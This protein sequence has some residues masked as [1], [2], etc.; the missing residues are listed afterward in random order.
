MLKQ[1]PK[2]K[3][4]CINIPNSMQ[5]ILKYAASYL[6]GNKRRVLMAK[7][8]KSLGDGGQRLAESV[9]GWNRK[10][11]RKGMHELNS[12]LECIDN[13]SGRGRRTAEYY[14][15]ELSKNI[16]EIVKPNSQ[17]DPTFRTN[18]IYTPLTA[19]EVRFRLIDL[20]GYSKKKLP[21]IRTIRNKMN[22]LNFHPD[23]VAKCRPLK[24]IKE[25]DAIFNQVF[26]INKEADNCDK[27]L[28]LSID[29]KAKVNIGLFSRGGKNRQG[30]KAL[31]HDFA[32]EKIITP[33]GIFLPFFD[34]SF[35]YFTESKVTADFLVDCLEKLWP[36][37][38]WRFNP[39]MLVINL[40]NGP[41]NNSHR[42]QFIKRITDFAFAN[43][44][45]IK[46][47]YYPPYHSKY[48]PIER[49]WGILENHW[50]G[51]VINSVEKAL[52]LARSM[53]YNGIHPNVE[54]IEGINSSGIKLDK[55]EMAYYEQK[56]VRLPGLEKWF[57]DIPV[58]C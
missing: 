26:K 4:I 23:K 11:I 46:L 48:N 30:A 33:V 50:N 34:E 16:T 24:K 21:C 10:T 55:K 6:K 7:T 39:D 8:V 3:S 38:K 47:A 45:S 28:R 44:V 40:D 35:M 20:K 31:D 9:L 32:P 56:I 49:V 17:V 36:K 51:E 54:L 29:A 2:E 43:T 52:G 25:T 18:K 22:S 15:S 42:T 37:L 12:G 53:T 19:K 27:V 14:F 13:F 5:D 58:I 1:I 57:V 41:E